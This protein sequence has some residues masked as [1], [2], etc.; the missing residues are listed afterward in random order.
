MPVV[1]S[2]LLE[3]IKVEFVDINID[4]EDDLQEI[5][6]CITKLESEM[7]GHVCNLE[8]LQGKDFGQV[9]DNKKE[10]QVAIDLSRYDVI[11]KEFQAFS[12][13]TIKSL[14]TKGIDLESIHTIRN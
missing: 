5:K 11:L 7:A 2:R 1:L 10:F 12:Q 8:E 3:T 6:E 4:T 13:D 9:R 14:Y